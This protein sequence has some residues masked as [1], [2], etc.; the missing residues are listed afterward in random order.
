MEY[1]TKNKKGW[2]RI[3]EVFVAILLIAG[4]VLIVIKQDQTER[5]DSSSTIYNS[6]VSVLRDIELNNSLRNEIVNIQD[7]SL[8]VE[9][10]EFN[11]S[12]PQTL[13]RI[14]GKTPS[15]LECVGKSCATDDVCLLSQTQNKTIYAESV[16]ISSNLQTYNPRQLKLFCWEK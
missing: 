16:I 11:V 12:A 2:I 4:V 14:T 10:S 8:P 7:S 13:A 3:V 1:Q 9:W 15:Y 6:M 5:N